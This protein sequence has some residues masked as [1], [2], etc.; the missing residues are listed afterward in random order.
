MTG[1]LEWLEQTYRCDKLWHQ[2]E[3]NHPLT[4]FGSQEGNYLILVFLNSELP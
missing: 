4:G 3:G 1:V 2:M